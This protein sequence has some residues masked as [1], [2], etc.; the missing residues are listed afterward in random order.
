VVAQPHLGSPL[1]PSLHRPS[2]QSQILLHEL[3]L[4]I[5]TFVHKLPTSGASLVSAV[6]KAKNGSII[7]TIGLNDEPTKA[8]V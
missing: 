3:W 7:L 6:F 4:Q 2:G 8:R 1:R 5:Y